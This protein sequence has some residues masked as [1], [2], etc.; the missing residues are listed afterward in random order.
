VLGLVQAE[1]GATGE[2]DGGDE[3]KAGIG[4]RAAEFHATLFE[5]GDGGLDVVAQQVELLV[6]SLLGRMHADFGGRQAE[7]EP[8]VACVDVGEFECVA[9]ECAYFFGVIGMDQSVGAGDHVCL[10]SE[11][12]V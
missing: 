8:A 9:E 1:F 2:R 10:F 7:D 12:S 6:A 3:A 5:I 11:L 4:D